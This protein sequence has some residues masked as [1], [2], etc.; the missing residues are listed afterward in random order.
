MG[1]NHQGEIAALCAI[2]QPSFGIITNIGKAHL[3]GFGGPQGVI[4]AK[5][6]LYQYIKKNNGTVFINSDNPLLMDLAA[7]VKKITYGEGE[8]ADYTGHFIESNPFVKW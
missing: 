4:K 6:E 3:E 7:S 2:A 5:N 8:K 1:A